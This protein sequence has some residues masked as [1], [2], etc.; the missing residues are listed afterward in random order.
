MPDVPSIAMWGAPGSGKTTFLAALSIALTQQASEWNLSGADAPSE[1]RLVQ[2]TSELHGRV[3][4]E[5]TQRY[6]ELHWVLGKRVAHVTRRLFR[7]PVTTYQPLSIGL[8]LVD[9]SGEFMGA[10][11]YGGAVRGEVVDRLKQSRGIVYVFDPD[12]EFQVGDAFEHTYSLCVQLRRLLAGAPDF[13]GKLPHYV[14]VCV[15]KF[16]ELPVLETARELG[17]LTID[18]DDPYGFPRVPEDDARQLFERLCEVSATGSGEM[19]L[20]TLENFFRPERIRFFV[21]SAVGF[22]VSE[23]TGRFDLDDPQNL[24]PD[25]NGAHQTRVRGPVRPINVVEPVLWLSEQVAG[26][27]AMA[28]QAMPGAQAAPGTAAQPPT[29]PQPASPLAGGS[30]AAP[31]SV[32]QPQPAA[33]PY[34]VAQPYS[35]PPSYPAAPQPYSAAQPNSVPRPGGQP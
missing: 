19:V 21:T 24:L 20:R 6:E 10:S 35:A 33:Q 27:F 1:A 16:D 2:M 18:D 34:L 14:A 4:P 13:D 28:G 7:K 26:Y 31:P 29:G 30:L 11:S 5:A 17:L 15:T 12:R 22:H 3:F 32:A 25:A 8:D 9:S 23:R